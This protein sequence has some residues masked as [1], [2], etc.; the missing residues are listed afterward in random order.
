VS[1]LR[2][3]PVVTILLLLHLVVCSAFI[4]LREPSIS[5]LEERER[6]RRESGY[7]FESNVDPIMFIAGR[8]LNGWNEWHG[9][10]SLWVK[11]CEVAN[12]PALVATV[13]V[14]HL[15]IAIYRFTG[16]GTF[17]HDTWIRA[18]LFLVFSVTQWIVVGLFIERRTRRRLTPRSS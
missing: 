17:V 16:S 13:T 1:V 18:F 11:I 2:R 14:G 4:L 9:G 3:H 5:H 6:M 10:E 7:H 15:P 8:R 12:L